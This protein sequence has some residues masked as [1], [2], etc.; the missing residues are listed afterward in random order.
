MNV[1]EQ[2]SRDR[3]DLGRWFGLDPMTTATEIRSRGHDPVLTR[4]SLPDNSDDI[5]NEFR[6]QREVRDGIVFIGVAQEKAQ[7]VNGRKIKAVALVTLATAE[8]T[9]V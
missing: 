8:Y 3:V 7:A 1:R 6:R 4:S 2:S 5:A 9:A